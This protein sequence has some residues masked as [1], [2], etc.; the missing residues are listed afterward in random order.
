MAERCGFSL[1]ILRPSL[2]DFIAVLPTLMR[3]LGTFDPMEL[4]NSAVTWLALKAACEEGISEVLTGDAAD[5][6]F[7]GYSYIFNMAPEQLRVMLGVPAAIDPRADMFALGVVLFELLTGRHPF[8]PPAPGT[9]AV[10][11][12]VETVNVEV[13]A[14]AAAYENAVIVSTATRTARQARRR[15]KCDMWVRL[16]SI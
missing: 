10:P 6:L 15:A 7:A 12:P 9:E 2:G 1:R 14:Y 13:A 16:S 8:P 11:E 5:E 3:I 4:R